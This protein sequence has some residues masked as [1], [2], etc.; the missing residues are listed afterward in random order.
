MTAG[1]YLDRLSRAADVA[2]HAADAARCAAEARREADV[3]NGA[4][5]ALELFGSDAEYEG[6]RAAVNAAVDR[7]KAASE[8]AHRACNVRI[9]ANAAIEAKAALN[10]VRDAARPFKR[11]D[12]LR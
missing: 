2:E 12:A 9:A 11:R 3:A 6:V 8:R 10:E 5:G 1:D 4:A 7:S